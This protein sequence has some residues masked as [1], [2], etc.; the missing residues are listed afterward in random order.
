MTPEEKQRARERREIKLR[1]WMIGFSWTLPVFSFVSFFDIWNNIAHANS[2]THTTQTTS[3]STTSNTSSKVLYKE[4][5]TSTQVAK[6]QEQ[7]AKLGFF[8][9]SITSY[10]GPVTANAVK[11]FQAQYGLP[12]TGAIDA[13]TLSALQTAVKQY[14]TNSLSSSSSNDDSGTSGQTE[15]SPSGSSGSSS[16]SSGSSSS[17]NFND[18][19]SGYGGYSGSPGV[20]QSQQPFPD[21][22]SSAS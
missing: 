9:N 14:Q 18:G 15:Q 7:L 13:K 1:R 4:G 20:T 2:S 22:S 10:Y 5:M 8:N 11:E 3:T 21:T 16:D 12:E 6:I 17:S 19:S